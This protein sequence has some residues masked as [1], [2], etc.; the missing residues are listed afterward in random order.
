MSEWLPTRTITVS[1]EQLDETPIDLM[2]LISPDR[3]SW[4]L[5]QEW[6]DLFVNGPE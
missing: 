6:L 5:S 3:P 4:A 2:S 1:R